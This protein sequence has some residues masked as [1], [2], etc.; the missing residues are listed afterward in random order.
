MLAGSGDLG[1][2]F[3]NRYFLIII[4]CQYDI[5][6]MDRCLSLTSYCLDSSGNRASPAE[7]LL[8]HINQP[9]TVKLLQ[10]LYLADPVTRQIIMTKV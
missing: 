6:D 5:H 1:S 4:F 3:I 2:R 8:G 10:M 9:G 7:M